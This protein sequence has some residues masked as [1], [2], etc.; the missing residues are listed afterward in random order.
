[1]L[2]YSLLLLL[3][4]ALACKNETATVSADQPVNAAD[5]FNLFKKL[6][7]P[8]TIA[9][10]NM[11]RMADTTLIPYD[12]LKQE[13]PDSVLQTLAA[14]K[15]ESLKIRPVGKITTEDEIYLIT[16][17]TDGKKSSLITYLFDKKK[18]YLNHLLLLS[19]QVDDNYVHSVNINTEP[20]FLIIREKTANNQ[21]NYSKAGYAY[22]KE[23]K[24]F[25]E[26]INDSNEDEKNKDIDR[27]SVV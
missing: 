22:S 11:M 16:L 9:D 13:V 3:F 1:M 8:N 20:T 24:G 12:V 17:V 7:L 5:F 25:V 21:Y 10:T 18:H 6:Q 26:V 27:K 15:P 19:N 2:R 4:F 23:S 14:K